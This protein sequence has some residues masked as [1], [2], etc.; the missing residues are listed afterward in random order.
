MSDSPETRIV[1]I[2]RD[3]VRELYATV[4]GWTRGDRDLAE[5]VVQ[6]TYLRA[7]RSWGARVPD[8]PAAW[9]RVVARNLLISELRRP[10]PSEQLSADPPASR[11]DDATRLSVAAA[12]ND[13]GR[14][15]A[16]LLHAF[17]VEGQSTAEIAAAR[18]ISSRAVEGRLRRARQ[19]L[20]R[21]L[22]ETDQENER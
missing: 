12:M 7:V 15:R 6:E 10:R 8:N 22:G 13:V 3:T 16:E 21:L 17:H 11:P 5:D 2:Y 20:G 1:S 4:C 19:A 9:L 18:R 14:E